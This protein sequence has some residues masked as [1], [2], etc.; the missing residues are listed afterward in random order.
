MDISSISQMSSARILPT[1]QFQT[2]QANPTDKAKFESLLNRS[3]SANK[4]NASASVTTISN[5]NTSAMTG[6]N[7]TR[8]M[9]IQTKW[10]EAFNRVSKPSTIYADNLAQDPNSL[11]AQRMAALE[12]AANKSME[13]QLLNVQIQMAS[14]YSKSAK[15]V[16]ETL[17]RQQG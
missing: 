10:S 3:D 7:A 15:Q 12:Q 1:N 9:E 11:S 14:Q 16:P 2:T 6:V 17:L 4:S 13:F 8:L 5:S